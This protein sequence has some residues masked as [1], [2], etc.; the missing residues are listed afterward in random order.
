MSAQAV[1]NERGCEWTDT[2][3]KFWRW[4]PINGEGCNCGVPGCFY[5][6][7]ADRKRFTARQVAIVVGKAEPAQTWWQR[8]AAWVTV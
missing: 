6:N 5:S 3:G 7:A 1:W 8:V 2:D 4:H